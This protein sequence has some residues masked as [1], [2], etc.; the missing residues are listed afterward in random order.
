MVALTAA[1]TVSATGQRADHGVLPKKSNTRMENS[2]NTVN[3]K[4]AAIEPFVDADAVAEFLSLTRRE[5]LKLTRCGTITGYPIS[6]ILRKTFKYRLSVVAD[7]M[8][9]FS[10]SARR[11]KHIDAPASLIGS[12]SYA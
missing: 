9:A 8:T 11:T 6:G 7:E 4:T 12:E 10:Q 2:L 1:K 5:V 3:W